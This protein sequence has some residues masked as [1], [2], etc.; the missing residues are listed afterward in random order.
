M[1]R[2]IYSGTQFDLSL[3]H[4][5][6]R[7][8]DRFLRDTRSRKIIE[9]KGALNRSRGYVLKSLS[10]RAVS[11]FLVIDSFS[12]ENDAIEFRD[13]LFTRLSVSVGAEVLTG[14]RAY[15]RSFI[16]V[17]VPG[18]FQGNSDVECVQKLLRNGPSPAAFPA[19]EF[20]GGG[21]GE[22][23][24]A[25]PR[26]ERSARART[27]TPRSHLVARLAPSTT[28]TTPSFPN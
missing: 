14:M 22:R 7:V 6:V 21:G 2:P 15:A 8:R 11:F 16:K 10:V 20:V 4:V 27:A 28:S 19:R 9:E 3:F 1:C 18:P 24:W 17:R 5:R 26:T 23:V 25:G 13:P 12:I